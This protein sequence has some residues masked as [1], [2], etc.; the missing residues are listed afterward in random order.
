MEKSKENLIEDTT[1][2]SEKK[3]RGFEVLEN[4]ANKI[5][6]EFS[7]LDDK[8]VHDKPIKE[9]DLEKVESVV[10]NLKIKL[11]TEILT[12]DEVDNIVDIDRDIKIWEDVRGNKYNS[13]E[14]YQVLQNLT[15]IPATLAKFISEIP[16]KIDG[17]PVDT[18]LYLTF[19]MVEH[20]SDETMGYLCKTADYLILDGLETLNESTAKIMAINWANSFKKNGSAHIE[21]NKLKTISI[22]A[23]EA[24]VSMYQNT[25]YDIYFTL[26]LN[27]C[28]N[29]PDEV[30]RHLSKVNSVLELNSITNLSDKAA[31][32]LSSSS[33]T[34]YLNGLKTLSDKAAE[35]ISKHNGVVHLG[36]LTH[37]SDEAAGYLSQ[38]RC[39]ID[40]GGLTSISDK[41]A[42]YL[43]ESVRTEDREGNDS[44]S[45]KK[46]TTLSEEASK[47][48]GQY[49]GFSLGLGGLTA[50]SDE[51]AK[52]LS[53]YKGWLDLDGLTHLSDK[54]AEYL[55]KLTK[56]GKSRVS[57]RL[58]LNGVVDISDKALSF[59]KRYTGELY[60][61]DEIK[62]R[63]NKLK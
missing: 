23:A 43:S 32:Y 58:H 62:T 26:Q 61:K 12:I 60:L 10:T 50:I 56:R 19:P 20:I 27:S 48:L 21:L 5:A 46:L 59:L 7:T 13:R 29:L 2:S 6:T 54:S 44:L 53:H 11:G 35:Y 16:W 18:R 45:L 40:F 63:M 8:V 4:E 22:G 3:G 36:G 55:S 17:K 31:E 33:A 57:H 1:D 25:D 28:E 38:R 14:L 34:I 42:K 39:A 52:N 49:R 51:T 37:I 9:G 47:C 41:T 15:Y 24:L 30:Y